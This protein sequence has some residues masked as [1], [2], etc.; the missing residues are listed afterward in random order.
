MKFND[1]WELNETYIKL[2][3]WSYFLIN[4]DYLYFLSF[5]RKQ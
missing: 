3:Y 2:V 4:I 5:S 1:K